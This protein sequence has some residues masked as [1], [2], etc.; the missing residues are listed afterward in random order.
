MQQLSLGNYLFYVGILATILTSLSLMTYGLAPSSE[1]T[2]IQN[3]HLE[4]PVGLSF[5]AFLL[6][7]LFIVTAILYSSSSNLLGNILVDASSIGLIFVNYL[8]YYVIYEVWHPS[9][10]LLPLF[11]SVTYDGSR[12]LQLDWGQVALIILL[13]RMYRLVKKSP[14]FIKSRGEKSTSEGFQPGGV[15]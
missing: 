4:V 2:F 5:S 12:S 10:S 8:N 9:I 1:T 7:I 13:Y 15:Q 6:L 11:V 14:P 3:Y